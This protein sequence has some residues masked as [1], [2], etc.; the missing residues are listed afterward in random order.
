[1]PPFL[2][3]YIFSHAA[4]HATESFCKKVSRIRKF[5]VVLLILLLHAAEAYKI[6]KFRLNFVGSHV[7]FDISTN[8]I[9]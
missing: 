7:L 4:R 9:E 8:T 1:M 5:H 6:Y 3:C 2:S